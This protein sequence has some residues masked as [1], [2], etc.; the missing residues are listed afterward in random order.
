M[1]RHCVVVGM[2]LIV[3][4]GCISKPEPWFPDGQVDSSGDSRIRG[5]D[6][7]LDIAE[8]DRFVGDDISPD[9]PPDI[10]D[11]QDVF[12]VREDSVEIIIPPDVIDINSEVSD[13][14]DLAD[15]VEL[16][17]CQPDCDGKECGE[18]GCGGMCGE[19]DGAQEACQDGIC[20][21]QPDCDGKECDDDGCDGSC[22]SCP[23]EGTCILG[24][25]HVNYCAL[26]LGDFGCCDDGV[27][28]WCEEEA[29]HWTVCTDNNPPYDSCGWDS[30]KYKCGGQGEDPEANYPLNCCTQ[31]CID[32]Q[33]GSDGCW[34]SCGVC[35]EWE[36][37][38]EGS[39][40]C[41]FESIQCD[42]VCCAP[43]EVCTAEQCC[44][45]DCEGKDCGS[46]G[47]GGSCGICNACGEEC[48][49]GLCTFTAC[50]GKECGSDNCG[51]V[52]GICPVEEH[53]MCTAGQCVCEFLFCLDACCAQNELCF[54]DQCCAADCTDKTCGD[55]GCGGSCGECDDTHA[56]TVDLCANGAC[57][58]TPDDACLI[59]EQC[60]NA[61]DKAADL[62]HECNPATATDVWSVVDDGATC[63][64]N[65]TC[66]SGQCTCVDQEC[67]ETC[68]VDGQVCFNG[69][70]C[71][72]L[73]VGKTCGD[74][75]CGGSCGECQGPQDACL[76][77]ACVCQP[78][79]DGIECGEDGCAGSCGECA[80]PQDACLEG[81]CVCQPA[82]DGIEC[83]ED[84]CAGSCGEC[85]GPQDACLEGECVCQPVCDGIECGDDGCGGS[86]G[87]CAGLQD[88]CLDSVC[89]CQPVCN[90]IE[91][92]DDGCAG[93]CGECEANEI[94]S[95]DGS[96]VIVSCDATECPYLPGYSSICNARKHCEYSRTEPTESWHQWDVWIYIPPG[97]FPMGGPEAEGGPDHE[98][99][100]H[101]VTIS[102]GFHVAKYEIV[103]EQYEACMVDSPETCD[104]PSTEDWDADG[105][106]LNSSDNGRSDHPQ[107]GL[108]RE[109]AL[110]FCEW[111]AV[112]GRLPTEA[113]WEYAATGPVH[114]KYPWG[115]WPEPDCDNNT[116]VMYDGGY[117]CD[118]GGTWPVT[119]KPA[120]A[121]WC[122]ALHM[123]GNVWEWSLDIWHDDYLDAPDDGSAWMDPDNSDDVVKGGEFSGGAS[124][125]RTAA[126]AAYYHKYDYANVGGRCIRPL[127]YG[128]VPD[129][130]GKNCGDDGCGGQ[131]GDCDD[132]DPCTTDTCSV[133][134]YCEHG[135][136][137]IWCTN[138]FYDGDQDDYG[139][140]GNLKCLCQPMGYYSA[141]QA[142]D[143]KDSNP[144][145]YPDAIDVCDGVDNNCDGTKDELFDVGE[146]CDGEDGDECSNG[147]F[148]CNAE[149]TDVECVNENHED[150]VETCGGGDEDC[151]GKT[152]EADAEGCT[153]YYKDKDT[154]GYGLD[155]AACLCQPFGQ[156]TAVQNGDC[157]DQNIA[158]HPGAKVCGIDADCDQ[159]LLDAGE[160]CDDGNADDW[161][162]CWDCDIGEWIAADGGL[163]D[164]AHVVPGTDDGFN[165][166]FTNNEKAYFE[167]YDANAVLAQ[168]L[169][170]L[171]PPVSL[172]Y[173]EPRFGYVP[174]AVG[175]IVMASQ[176]V[177]G[178]GPENTC[179]GKEKCV[180]AHQFSPDG[181]PIGAWTRIDLESTN[182][183]PVT[184]KDVEYLKFSKFA[185][186][187]TQ[188]N[189][190]CG[191]PSNDLVAAFA[192]FGVSGPS[193][194]KEVLLDEAQYSI[195][196]VNATAR[197]G[198]LLVCWGINEKT[199]RAQFLN[200]NG[201]AQGG[202]LELT[203]NE[204]LVDATCT[205][206]SATSGVVF[207]KGPGDPP[208]GSCV[209]ASTVSTSGEIG[210]PIEIGLCDNIE[211]GWSVGDSS[212]V[213]SD[214]GG[215]NVARLDAGSDVA[216]V[217]FGVN[218]D[219]GLSH[220]RAASLSLTRA[221]VV[222]KTMNGP[223]Q[224]ND[225]LAVLRFDQLGNPVY[226]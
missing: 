166:L 48:L 107:N 10:L 105:W 199:S 7:I 210:S 153:T 177:N 90:E 142:G 132:G 70:C 44:L 173:S 128:C 226:K 82:C 220:P 205:M 103:V 162:G 129:C 66:Q 190:S 211:V 46:D 49:T 25:C 155:L 9:T 181:T 5:G 76:E 110:A 120:G 198:S 187:W 67:G 144:N 74:D 83:G 47:C 207:W 114:T 43:G 29:L 172:G 221:V 174:V 151:D 140:S 37:C 26:G 19:C 126:R 134:Q 196:N 195:T 23:D 169:T 42:Q 133:E 197:D 158:V 178:M 78:A 219:P 208:N 124:D 56:C 30:G 50:E 34:G 86:C 138:Y 20:T 31:D 41:E 170:E 176:V 104:P 62:C 61:G 32:K 159:S 145:I 127:Y 165:V 69:T 33:C 164:S 57:M 64:V 6:G 182:S 160:S 40:Q 22:G 193:A 17:V 113:E 117:G 13:I 186:L 97:S 12:D 35:G 223:S 95:L 143:C 101:T 136:D 214:Y 215:A 121:A 115:D 94:C 108:W 14:P 212:F 79:C 163:V 15:I 116:A 75:S 16:E 203:D 130:L 156:F 73:C 191:F 194:H 112:G 58:F 213:L 183:C 171:V 123:A 45:P 11:L 68:C 201:V 149:H 93:S 99:P 118:T 200:A 92:G 218:K 87:E 51:G 141:T 137:P 157:N 154:D 135:I 18:D 217:Q 150:V 28:I 77:G 161:D 206:N 106:G 72:P 65:A 84:G 216:T 179:G 139:I 27:I 71:Q 209:F 125:L 53:K 111:V 100:V 167:R 202:L 98:R 39:C 4:G 91:C 81:A 185:V 222:W 52:C 24:Q 180:A 1:A 131:C 36:E 54:N 146:E 80:G 96:C 63:D 109:E 2:L 3:S 85:A 148:T 21:C 189:S 188:A 152:D 122:G 224:T 225:K 59:E 119:S 102:E 147:T 89:I 88:A 8:T 168:S 184:V 60:Y 55:D 175:G 38:D 204:L 192:T